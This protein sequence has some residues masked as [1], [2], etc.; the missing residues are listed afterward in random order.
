M[1]P[2][3]TVREALDAARRAGV[4][5]PTAW[6]TALAEITDAHWADALAQTSN[7]WRRAYQLE[8]PTVGISRSTS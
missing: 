4:P 1:N 8:P 5:F 7:A 2:A 6:H 3:V